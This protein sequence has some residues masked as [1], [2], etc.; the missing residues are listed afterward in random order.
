M[1]VF[2]SGTGN[3]EFVAHTL[4]QELHD[5]SLVNVRGEVLRSAALDA[6]AD[7]CS[8]VWV[9]PVYSWGLPPVMVDF[10]RRLDEA[11]GKGYTHYCVLTCGDDVGL[12]ARQWRKLLREKGWTEG[13]SVWSVQMPNNYVLMKG[14]DVDPKEIEL[15]KLSACRAR[16]SDIARAIASGQTSVTDVVTGSWAWFKSVVIRPWFDRFA[17]SPKP[18]YATGGCVGCGLCSRECP[19]GDITMSDHH[20]QWGTKCAMCL[21]CYHVC[22]QRAIAYGRNTRN[23]GQYICPLNND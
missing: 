4:Q 23:K 6:P 10:I 22:P 17:M 14:F 20:P 12:T 21:R 8:I 9:M 7:G 1:I 2:F 15:K 5:G 11:F 18:F 13:E 16:I 3:S 19:T